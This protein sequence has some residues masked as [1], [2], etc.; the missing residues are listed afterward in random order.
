MHYLQGGLIDLRYGQA[1]VDTGGTGVLLQ[2]DEKTRFT[3][4]GSLCK[5]ED[6]ASTLKD[7]TP[8]FGGTPR[9]IGT[10]FGLAKTLV[11]SFDEISEC[12]NDSELT[13]SFGSHSCCECK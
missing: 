8:G 5:A 7:G 11:T 2:W 9:I 13:R 10:L 3:L 12:F 6:L 1:S 4:N